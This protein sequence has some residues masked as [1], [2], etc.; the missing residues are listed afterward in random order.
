MKKLILSVFAAAMLITL[1]PVQA[2]ADVAPIPLTT[3]APAANTTAEAEAMVARLNE[4][5]AMDIKSL[6][7]AERKQL[8]QEVKAM[9]NQ[10]RSSDGIYL[11]VG[12]I[13]IIAL[14]LILL[15]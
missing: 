12:A 13:V 11:S 7:S 4:I 14:L 3:S 1:A 2:R 6:S 15:L 5:K 9:K 10:M 8:R